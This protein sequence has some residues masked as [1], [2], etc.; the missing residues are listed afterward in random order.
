VAALEGAL[1]YHP[2]YADARYHLA[3]VLDA[4]GRHD[5][6]Q[7]HWLAFLESAPDSPWSQEARAR[8]SDPEN[9]QPSKPQ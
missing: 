1:A 9:P 8:L 5:E 2:D 7:T 4:L 6:A 3:R